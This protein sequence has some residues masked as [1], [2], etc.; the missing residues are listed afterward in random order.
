MLSAEELAALADT[1]DANYTPEGRYSGESVT[2]FKDMTVS[3]NNNKSERP[4]VP[5][6]RPPPPQN[7]SR[8]VSQLDARSVSGAGVSTRSDA[9][10]SR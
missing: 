7:V 2:H 10:D 6:L 9:V 3:N 5:P 4:R 8:R 1:F